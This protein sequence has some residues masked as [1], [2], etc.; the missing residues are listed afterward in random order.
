MK[1]ITFFLLL[2]CASNVFAQ[3]TAPLV[4]EYLAIKDAL[5]AGKS[6]DASSTAQTFL[7]KMQGLTVSE[8][9]ADEKTV[10]EKQKATL[11][12]SASAIYENA[13][14]DKQRSAFA[15]L[16]P[17]LWALVKAGKNV[18]EKLYYDYCPMKKSYWISADE[19]IKNPFYGSQMLSCGSI[20]EK[21]N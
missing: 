11:K 15:N 5:V 14:L 1:P 4:A 13:D 19:K 8:F 2:F 6:T 17:A 18:S 12:K 16:S 9:S 3:T 7:T 20:S 10:W 21:I